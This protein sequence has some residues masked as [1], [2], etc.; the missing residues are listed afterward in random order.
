MVRRATK[1]DAAGMAA[2]TA[3]LQA[4][5]LDTVRRRTPTT[6]AFEISEIETA[7]ANGRAFI[8]V[9][10]A[11]DEVVGML[12]LW[13]TQEPHKRH[14]ARFGVSVR[15]DWRRKGVGRELVQAAIRDAKSWPH[16]CRMELECTPNNEPAIRLYRSLGFQVEGCCRKSTNLGNG[17]QDMLLMS[18]VW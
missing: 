4:E 6:E 16:F 13:A 14:A 17:P 3:A 2:F 11:Q 7:E 12:G 5:Q 15:K 1:G 10:V 8:L 9:A 18:L